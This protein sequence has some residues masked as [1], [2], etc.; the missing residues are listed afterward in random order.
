MIQ[1]GENKTKKK[2]NP[3]QL[4]RELPRSKHKMLSKIGIF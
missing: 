3:E 1:E 2:P 4:F